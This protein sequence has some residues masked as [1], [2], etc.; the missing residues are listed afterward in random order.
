M[1]IIS[2]TVLYLS[3]YK[4]HKEMKA[5]LDEATQANTRMLADLEA[6]MQLMKEKIGN[7]DQMQD[8]KISAVRFF[9]SS[10]IS[11]FPL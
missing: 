3:E 9:I 6:R 5:V 11:I 10:I 1:H 2:V 8:A 7:L 4:I